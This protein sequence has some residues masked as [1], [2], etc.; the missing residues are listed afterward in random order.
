[1]NQKEDKTYYSKVVDLSHGQFDLRLTF[2]ARKTGLKIGLI[3]HE[4]HR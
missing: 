4:N 1:M 2:H 3:C